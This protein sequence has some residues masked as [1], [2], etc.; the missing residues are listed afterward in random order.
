MPSDEEEL[1]VLA[2]STGLATSAGALETRWRGVKLEVRGLHERLF[3]RPL[4]SAV[5]ATDGD[6]VLTNDQAVD[7][8]GAIGFV[9][10]PGALSH[11]RALTQ[12]TSRRATIQR[13]LLPVLLRWMAEGPAAD[14]ALLAFRRLSDTLGSRA[15]SSGCSATR[16]APRTP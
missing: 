14:R 1:R 3:Y 4:L 9:D 7:R 11:I 13:N 6:I 15:G 5:A 10:P 16:R 12:G 2:R 8:L